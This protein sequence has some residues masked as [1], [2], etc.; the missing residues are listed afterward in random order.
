MSDVS[1]PKEKP[2]RQRTEQNSELDN[3]IWLQDTRDSRLADQR[4]QP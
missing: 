3:L 4:R 1:K 2:V